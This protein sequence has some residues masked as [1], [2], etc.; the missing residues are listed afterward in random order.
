[1]GEAGRGFYGVTYLVRRRS[2]GL[3]L[4]LETAPLT[5]HGDDAVMPK[6]SHSIIT[7]ERLMLR[8]LV[9]PGVLRY[10]DSFVR[11]GELCVVQE[12]TRDLTLAAF[13]LLAPVAASSSFAPIARGLL[14]ALAY[15]HG[16]GIV[17][18]CIKPANVLVRPDGTPRLAGFG[19]ARGA[20]PDRHELIELYMAPEVLMGDKLTPASDVWSLGATLYFVASGGAHAINNRSNLVEAG[21]Y[22]ESWHMPSLPQGTAPGAAR[23]IARM[24]TIDAAARP[25]ASELLGDPFFA[26]DAGE[27]EAEGGARVDGGGGVASTPAAT[28]ARA[29]PT[30]LKLSAY[31]PTATPA[32]GGRALPFNTADRRAAPPST[33]TATPSHATVSAAAAALAD[34]NELV[35]A[36]SAATA[37]ADESS[38]RASRLA[39]ELAEARRLRAADAEAAAG[40][41]ERAIAVRARLASAAQQASESALAAAEEARR[42]AEASVTQ[43]QQELAQADDRLRASR[44]AATAAVNDAASANAACAAA[45]AEA[46]AARARESVAAYRATAAAAERDA[47]VAESARHMTHSAELDAT[48][49]DLR[50]QLRHTSEQH[51]ST[52]TRLAT[53][54]SEL[55]QL[56]G[57][58]AE[59]TEATRAARAAADSAAARAA[60]AE[61]GVAASRKAVADAEARAAAAAAALDAAHEAHKQECASLLSTHKQELHSLVSEH[62]REHASLVSAH[63]RDLTSQ[64]A[65]AAATLDAA[66]RDADAALQKALA[67]ARTQ[68]EA[69]TARAATALAVLRVDV[70]SGK[71]RVQELERALA[72]AKS[73]AA[74]ALRK[75]LAQHAQHLQDARKEGKG[76]LEDAQRNAAA[77]AARCDAATAELDAGK[78]KLLAAEAALA[79]AQERAAVS[80]AA[81][82]E[83]QGKAKSASARAVAAERATAD[84]TA[85]LA[86]ALQRAPPAPQRFVLIT[87]RRGA[88]LLLCAVVLLFAGAGLATLSNVDMAPRAFLPRHAAVD[89]I[90]GPPPPPPPPP[91]P[92]TTEHPTRAAA[93]LKALEA[94][95]AA[96]MNAAKALRDQVAALTRESSDRS[97]AA[98]AA[99]HQY[100]SAQRKLDAAAQH[101]LELQAALVRCVGRSISARRLPT[102]MPSSPDPLSAYAPPPPPPL[103]QDAYKRGVEAEVGE[104]V[105]S[106]VRSQAAAEAEL[107]TRI[108]ELTAEAADAA[109]RQHEFEEDMRARNEAAAAASARDMAAALEQV[110]AAASRQHADEVARLEAQLELEVLRR[111]AAEEFAA[112]AVSEVIVATPVAVAAAI[113]S[114]SPSV[115]STTTPH[116]PMLDGQRIR[117]GLVRLLTALASPPWR[118]TSAT[119]SRVIGA[120]KLLLQ[121]PLRMAMWLCAAAI[122]VAGAVSTIFGVGR[123][124]TRNSRIPEDWELIEAVHTATHWPS[125]A[126]EERV[127]VLLERGA[128]PCA[129]SDYVSPR[130]SLPPRPAPAAVIVGAYMQSPL[131]ANPHYI[132]L[133]TQHDETALQLARAGGW[134]GRGNRHVVD[135][136]LEAMNERERRRRNA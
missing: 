85:K 89:R 101:E 84:A 86:A 103:S 33:S 8:R 126:S 23:L 52:T 110:T 32:R 26:A 63:E 134:C 82:A 53:L 62:K 56:Q 97:R 57:A 27:S 44:A 4:A 16:C 13:V 75:Q 99:Q 131:I 40:A 105:A 132:S 117:D 83:A 3:E 78:S 55:A 71:T 45:T 109:S 19:A 106:A 73:E 114:S 7:R 61:Q 79:D 102:C 128:N 87:C 58:L 66:R 104:R 28:A 15:V 70:D 123:R 81:L 43:L 54:E 72:A 115:S 111:R 96:E 116:P 47:A 12:H 49:V 119:A 30:F 112:S 36:L 108:A 80:D 121:S 124:R 51:T 20:P 127:R 107:R 48:V 69:E 60:A 41:S 22:R 50:R 46:E 98:E 10:Y 76:A 42:E 135:L 37:R 77:A 118:A 74:E 34:V 90:F 14:D 91:P 1:M 5:A 65:T 17:H 136:L 95:L 35:A 68:A 2:D 9:H 11:D 93:T 59:A 129:L 6:L 64:R 122:L 18:R 113:E 24:L 31:S 125:A 88:W 39:A 92:A 120:A 100:E 67:T 130:S 25:T 29:S 38:T 94:K 21:A 133:P